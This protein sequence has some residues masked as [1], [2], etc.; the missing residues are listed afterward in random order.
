MKGVALSC[1][2][3]TDGPL[4]PGN[5]QPSHGGPTPCR[6]TGALT[7]AQGRGREVHVLWG[8]GE[9]L[10]PLG[11]KLFRKHLLKPSTCQAVHQ[12]LAALR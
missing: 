9:G 5:S 3:D 6:P 1:K 2:N 12:A 7:V 11:Q 8:P 4:P 10:P